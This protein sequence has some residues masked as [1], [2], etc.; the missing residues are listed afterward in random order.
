MTVRSLFHD[1][2]PARLSRAAFVA[3]PLALVA[4]AAYLQATAVGHVVGAGLSGP[5]LAAVTPANAEAAEPRAR[6]GGHVKSLASF[7]LFGGAPP[8]S[9]QLVV[10]A[11]TGS[12]DLYAAPVCQGITLATLATFADPRASLATLRLAASNTSLTVGQGEPVLDGRVL[13]V[14]GDRVWIERPAASGGICQAALF[15]PATPPVVSASAAP[16][17]PP[18]GLAARVRS[19]GEHEVE[20]DRA[21]VDEIVERGTSLARAVR[22]SPALGPDGNVRGYSVRSIA[23]GPDGALASALGLRVGDTLLSVNGFSVAKPEELLAAYGR[24]RLAPR[25]S[26]EIERQGAPLTLSAIPR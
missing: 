2:V 17:A 11:P 13:F 9:A 1:V 24:L 10:P 22:V 4:V 3:V 19:I 21:A 16:A 20:V 6:D 7:S 5:L 12:D 26:L 18:N 25:I 15:A 14:G 8:S 23:P